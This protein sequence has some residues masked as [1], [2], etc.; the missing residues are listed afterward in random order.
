VTEH[1]IIIAGLASVFAMAVGI[2]G[3][4]VWLIRRYPRRPLRVSDMEIPEPVLSMPQ[5]EGWSGPLRPSSWIAI[6]THRVAAVQAALNLTQSDR[7]ALDH[8]SSFSV[9]APTNGWVLV[10]GPQL[11]QPEEDVDACFR[12]VVNLSRK[13]GHAQ[14][15]SANP[16]LYYHAWA[17]AERGR[18]IRAYA[19]AGK[20]LWL[21]G[22]QTNEEKRLGLACF[23]YDEAEHH[24][25]GQMEAAADNIE[26]IPLLAARWSVDP[27]PFLVCD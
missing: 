11:P 18:I 23:D 3:L 27:R 22:L 24:A 12:L 14:F 5:P 26:K 15:F 1:F 13:F 19:W 6:R 21:Q 8:S 17:R 2:G 20:T 25:A 10:Q 7:L 16:L 9:S 4:M